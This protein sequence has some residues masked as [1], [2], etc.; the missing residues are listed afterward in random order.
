M[1]RVYLRAVAP[2]ISK[3]C[4]SVRVY[5]RAVAPS[6]SNLLLCLCLHLSICER[7]TRFRRGNTNSHRCRCAHGFYSRLPPLPLSGAPPTLLPPPCF[8]SHIYT[9]TR[10]HSFTNPGVRII[11]V[12]ALNILP[13]CLYYK[14]YRDDW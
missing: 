5:L 2:C 12:K 6:K 14:Y 1:L 10:T 9:Y 8:P 11:A 7:S 13:V 3:N 4:C